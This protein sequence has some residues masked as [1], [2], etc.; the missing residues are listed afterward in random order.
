MLDSG[1]LRGLSHARI[2]IPNLSLMKGALPSLRERL[3]KLFIK[4][5]PA[6]LR[7]TQRHDVCS[8]WSYGTRTPSSR[9]SQR[10]GQRQLGRHLG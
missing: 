7:A 9:I 2:N 8:V 10:A 1:T 3:S 6:Q 4:T 5:G